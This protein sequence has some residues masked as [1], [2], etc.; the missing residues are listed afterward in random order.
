MGQCTDRLGARFWT[1]GCRRWLR[2]AVGGNVPP[3]YSPRGGACATGQ[4]PISVPAGRGN[5]GAAWPSRLWRVGRSVPGV[6]G[7]ST[8]YVEAPVRVGHAGRAI[9]HA[10]WAASGSV[11]QG[12]WAVPASGRRSLYRRRRVRR[13]RCACW[14]SD[15]GAGG[16][17]HRTRGL[18][19]RRAL[20]MVGI[21]R[22]DRPRHCP[23]ERSH[24]S[25]ARGGTDAT[26]WRAHH[27]RRDHRA[28]FPMAIRN[29]C[30][31]PAA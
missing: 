30:A 22:L 8:W 18:P 13:R 11:P 15:S 23:H 3:S 19:R 26:G 25:A 5:T 27:R 14:R 29:I 21:D 12:D 17:R 10:P 7:A 2:T 4:A 16:I 28:S 31:S 9:A 6:W 24:S 1:S 20:L